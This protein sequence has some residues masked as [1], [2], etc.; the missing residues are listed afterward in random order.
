MQQTIHNSN[1]DS[2]TINLNTVKEEYQHYVETIK[3]M[4][5][6]QGDV[7]AMMFVTKQMSIQE[8]MKKY[9]EEGKESAMKEILN[10][11]GND[12]I[13]EIDYDK[14]SQEDKDK[15]LPI[16]MF[17]VLKRKK[18]EDVPTVVYKGC[19]Q[20]KKMYHHLCLI[21]IHLNSLQQ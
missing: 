16:L 8:G 14:L 12:C 10:L 11:T 3:W 9:K 4:D 19:I 20:I 5:V 6:D 17:M 2:D 7:T 15:A 13:G 21:S 18:Q 1:E